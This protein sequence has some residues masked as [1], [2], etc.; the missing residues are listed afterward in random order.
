MKDVFTTR[1]LDARDRAGDTLLHVRTVPEELKTWAL[2]RGLSV[3]MPRA[4]VD[5]AEQQDLDRA[6]ARRATASPSDEALA[7]LV[8]LTVSWVGRNPK[9]LPLPA[10]QQDYRRSTLPAQPARP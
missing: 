10:G 8:R 9:A 4:D 6:I 5:N 7:A 2:E 1:T 3:D